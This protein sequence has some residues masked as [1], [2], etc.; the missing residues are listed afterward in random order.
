MRFRRRLRV[1]QPHGYTEYEEQA[2]KEA[3]RSKCRERVRRA[4]AFGH[5]ARDQCTERLD[6]HDHRRVHRH[7]AAAQLIGHAALHHRISGR[8]L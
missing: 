8:H 3:D 2:P 1:P 6:T 4:N 7:D 5:T